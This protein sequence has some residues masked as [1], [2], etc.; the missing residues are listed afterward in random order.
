[1][2]IQINRALTDRQ[3]FRYEL[4]QWCGNVEDA[5]KAEAFIM[6]G[7]DNPVQV[8]SDSSQRLS[9]SH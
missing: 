8:Q 3:Q 2:E 4:L 7:D 5:E 1:M 6:G 9:G